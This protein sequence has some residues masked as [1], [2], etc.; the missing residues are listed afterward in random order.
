MSA[1]ERTI[2][3]APAQSRQAVLVERSQDFDEQK[4]A[5]AGHHAVIQKLPSGHC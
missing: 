1:A 2:E 5:F 3:T 4:Y